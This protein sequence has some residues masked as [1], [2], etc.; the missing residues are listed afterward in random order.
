SRVDYFGRCRH[1]CHIRFMRVLK[2][3]NI[4]RDELPYKAPFQPYL[5]WF[6]FFF[7]VL[8]LLTNGFTV[9]IDW[10]T[11]TFF[12]CYVS[13]MLFI[14]LYVGHKLVYRTKIIPVSEV[15]ISKG[16]SGQ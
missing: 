10:D 4:P 3:Q 14:V 7:N 6:G 15:D 11:S 12:A 9:F 5:S 8:I 1:L 13:V 2:Y 16:R